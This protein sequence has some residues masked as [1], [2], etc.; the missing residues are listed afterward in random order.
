MPTWG[1]FFAQVERFY[2]QVKTKKNK[3]LHRLE[4]TPH[5]ALIG[6]YISTDRVIPWNVFYA[7]I[8]SF[9]C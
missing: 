1:V 3:F 2:A 5:S 7:D 4:S 9:I 6:A 8:D